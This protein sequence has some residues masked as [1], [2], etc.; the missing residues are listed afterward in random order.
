M[1]RAAARP[2]MEP[3]HSEARLEAGLGKAAHVAGFA[4]PFEAMRQD[5]FAS[6][7]ALRPLRLHQYLNAWLGLVKL[8]LDRVT[9]RVQPAR[10]E[11]SR[12]R[13]EV[14]VGYYRTER[15]QSIFY[16]FRVGAFIKSKRFKVASKLLALFAE[17]ISF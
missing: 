3:V 8:R 6:C 7:V 10:P 1:R 12:D 16:R 11:I 14:I 15:P 9:A 13:Q 4:R 17:T 2:H 5:N